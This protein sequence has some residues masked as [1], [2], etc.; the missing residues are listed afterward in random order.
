[1]KVNIDTLEVVPDSF[2]TAENYKNYAD[3]SYAIKPSLGFMEYLVAG[4]IHKVGSEYIQ[5]WIVYKP[6]SQEI[7]RA[8][9][10]HIEQVLN[11]TAK[12]HGYDNISTAISY[13]D[14]PAIPRFQ[15]EGKAFRRWR[16]IVWNYAY[17]QLGSVQSNET[18]IPSIE[19][20][21]EQLPKLVI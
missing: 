19:S 1:M 12:D 4:S 21:I 6:S 20:F 18:P 17:E 9:E 5:D 7:I 3:F 13:A 16:S 8:F 15:I 11:Q 14:E 10:N 2:V